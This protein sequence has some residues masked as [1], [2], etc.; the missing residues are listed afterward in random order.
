MP[1]KESKAFRCHILSSAALKS[2]RR[3]SP[4][5]TF[6]RLHGKIFRK[7]HK[8]DRVL[9]SYTISFACPFPL[10]AN[11]E[12]LDRYYDKVIIWMNIESVIRGIHPPDLLKSRLVFCDSQLEAVQRQVVQAN[13][14]FVLGSMGSSIQ[15][16]L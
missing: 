7:V 2:L 14:A 5:S 11:C 8:G 12:S 1:V 6:F 9:R 16:Y 13:I 10:P 4:L 15:E 3:D